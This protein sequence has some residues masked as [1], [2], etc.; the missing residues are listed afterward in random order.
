KQYNINDNVPISPQTGIAVIGSGYWGKNLVR[1]YYAIGNLKLICDKNEST[2]NAF[3]EQYPGIETCMAVSDVVSRRDIDGVVIATPAET[4]Y[5]IAREALLAGKHVYVEKP[6]VLDE[7]QGAELIALADEKKRVLMVGHLLQYHPVFVRLKEMARA[8][9]LGR[10][11]YIYSNRLNLGKIRREEN[12]LWSFA[13]HDISMIL[14]LAHE[15]PESVSATAGYYL[16]KKIA[17][18]TT[19][20][21]AFTSGLQAHIF[22]SWLHP[23]KEQKL[24]VVGDRKMAV[25]DDTLSWEDKLLLYGHQINWQNNQPVPVKA[26]PERVDIPKDEPLKQECLHFLACMANGRQ[27][28]TNGTEGLHVLK[29]LNAAQKSLDNGGVKIALDTSKETARAGPSLFFLH[30]T[31]LV[32]KNCR[33]GQKTKIWHF[34]HI[35]SGSHIGENTNIGQN[36]VVGPEVTIGKNCKIQNNVSVYKGVTLEDGVFCGPSMVFTNIYNP[37]AE[38]P[39]MDQVRPTMVRHG[40]TLG[41][42]CTIVCG[43]TIGRYALVGAGAVVNKN[44]PDHALM[45]GNPARQIGW[46]CECG[47]RLTDDL[48]CLVC[49][50]HYE[51]TTDGIQVNHLHPA[52]PPPSEF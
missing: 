49:N 7:F 23:F 50:K 26:E 11:N 40:A 31:A 27:P 3:S 45:V 8:G 44:V 38:I 16:H 20:H 1:N 28:I 37:R 29:V 4:H 13:P 19:T 36:V 24:V 10:I 22:V 34:S 21:I 35:L 46:V 6:L 30:P 18:V 5:A 12:I 52:A 42:N 48:S 43:V 25:F 9:E 39:K 33:I 14:G 17:D 41:A 51:K 15:S 2:L 47:E 32:D